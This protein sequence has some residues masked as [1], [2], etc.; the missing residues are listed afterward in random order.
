MGA[1]Q[2][3]RHD[4]GVRPPRGSGELV[5]PDAAEASGGEAGTI[6]GSDL[7][8]LALAHWLELGVARGADELAR[9]LGRTVD[10]EP[11]ADDGDA[12]AD[13]A[14]LWI[15]RFRGDACGSLAVAQMPGARQRFGTAL[16]VAFGAPRE[17]APELQQQLWNIVLNEVLLTLRGAL[18]LTLVGSTPQHAQTPLERSPL[19]V[20]S[21][22]AGLGN[23]EVDAQLE[24][25][26]EPATRAR[27]DAHLRGSV[28]RYLESFTTWTPA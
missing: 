4:P 7:A 6:H 21:F 11:R 26:V 24:I 28:T 20:V 19:V 9:R 5:S 23:D 8:T 14:V 17:S 3:S 2:P 27:F 13:S 10:L 1:V 15:Q 18:D 22:S 16:S 12:P 25:D